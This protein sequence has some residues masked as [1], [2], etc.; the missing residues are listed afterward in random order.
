M[1]N[2]STPVGATA[3]GLI[4]G[5]AGTLAMDAL[6]FARYRRAG[7]ESGFGFWE[8]SW[9]FQLGG[10]TR[11]DAG[12]QGPG[13]GPFQRCCQPTERHWSTTSG[14]W[15]YGMPWLAA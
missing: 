7:G 2:S 11:T 1:G 4:A 8:F 15:A 14:I 13:G 12:G 6:L 5:A 9:A 10:R 3:E